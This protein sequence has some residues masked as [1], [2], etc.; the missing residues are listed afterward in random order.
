MLIYTLTLNQSSGGANKSPN[1]SPRK[2]DFLLHECF[3]RL[4]LK[5]RQLAARLFMVV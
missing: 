2:I 4:G 5:L 1:K 3:A